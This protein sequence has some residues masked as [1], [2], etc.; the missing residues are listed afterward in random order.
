MVSEIQLSHSRLSA[1]DRGL[2]DKNDQFVKKF[3]NIVSRKIS[4]ILSFRT[5]IGFRWYDRFDRSFSS[6]FIQKDSKSHRSIGKTSLRLRNNDSSNHNNFFDP[7]HHRFPPYRL[8]NTFTHQISLTLRYSSQKETIY[9]T[10]NDRLSSLVDYTNN[11]RQPLDNPHKVPPTSSKTPLN[12]PRSV[13]LR[14]DRSQTLETIVFDHL[15]DPPTRNEF[16]KKPRL[17]G[18]IPRW[19]IKGE[20]NSRLGSDL[21]SF[22]VGW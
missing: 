6:D 14:F 22:R 19:E 3:F 7:N 12:S 18:G 9:T 21:G 11:H 4:K 2:S 16:T 20:W 13:I 10:T 1:F 17:L 8:S 5:I 15:V